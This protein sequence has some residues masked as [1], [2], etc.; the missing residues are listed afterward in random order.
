LYIRR[1]QWA[2]NGGNL[3]K[4]VPRTVGRRIPMNNERNKSV[5][6]PTNSGENVTTEPKT[7]EKR[8]KIDQIDRDFYTE[9]GG[10]G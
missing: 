1:E 10:E 3:R 2:G 7:E 9:H 5:T 6:I 8:D 4:F